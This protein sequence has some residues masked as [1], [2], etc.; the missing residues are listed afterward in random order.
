MKPCPR[1]LRRWHWLRRRL[2]EFFVRD[3]LVRQLKA[4]ML[5]FDQAIGA[6]KYHKSQPGQTHWRCECAA[7]EFWE[8]LRRALEEPTIE[9]REEVS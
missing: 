4:R 8:T 9:E 6:W 1:W 7:F 2:D 3:V 5:T